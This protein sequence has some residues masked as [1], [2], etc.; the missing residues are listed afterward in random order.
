MID[1]GKISTIL[2]SIFGI[3]AAAIIADPSLL[4]GFGVPAQYTAVIVG[5][6]LVLYNALF[7]RNPSVTPE[8]SA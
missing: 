7:P 3:F 8:D 5:I 2:I 6:L 4:G 1:N